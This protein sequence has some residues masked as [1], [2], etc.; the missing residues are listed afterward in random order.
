MET[1]TR[2]EPCGI[3]DTI[4]EALSDLVVSIRAAASDLGHGLHPDSMREL[5]GMIR[6][7]NSYYS[8]LI[9]GHNTRPRDIEAA[10]AGLEL[11]SEKRPL[12][13]EAAAH[14]RVQDWIDDLAD[15]GELVE[16]TSV[17]FICEVH[18]RFYQAMP[19]EFR[20]SELGT[21]RHEILPGEFR[22]KGQEVTVGR[23]RPPLAELVPAFLEYY[24]KR[25]QGLT[26]GATGQ[27]LSIPAAHHRLNYIHP[28]LDGNGRVSR[29]VSH[30][31]VRSAGVGGHGLWSI[32][33]GLARGLEDRGEYKAKMDMADTVR[34][35]DRD[36]RGG[37][38]ISLKIVLSNLPTGSYG[39]C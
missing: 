4:P 3:E 11:D 17:T 18:R 5:R 39:S 27:I 24:A 26:K 6:I 33:R 34:Q 36:G 30:A 1:P 35:G 16:P 13:E 2:I 21:V 14:V 19:V 20:F 10:L 38:V 31:M 37:A 28:F 29:L 8:N 7:M 12:A 32:S 15:R 22:N 25:Y 9:E 23:H